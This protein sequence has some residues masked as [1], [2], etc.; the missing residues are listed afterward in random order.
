MNRLHAVLC[1][2]FALVFMFSMR[3]AWAETSTDLP[4]VQAKVETTE[5]YTMRAGVPADW[6]WN[7]FRAQGRAMHEWPAFW[8]EA[9]AASNIP[10]T[11]EAWRRIPAGTKITMP[12]DP[13]AVAADTERLRFIR[14]RDEAVSKLTEEIVALQASYR[15]AQKMLLAYGF[16]AL[17][18]GVLAVVAIAR[19]LRHRAMQARTNQE[20]H[21]DVSGTQC[22][23][24]HH[25]DETAAHAEFPGTTMPHRGEHAP[26][27]PKNASCC[28]GEGEAHGDTARPRDTGCCPEDGCTPGF[29]RDGTVT[30]ADGRERTTPIHDRGDHAG[31]RH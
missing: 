30:P 23:N 21:T 13:K 15:Q 4:G 17:V 3:L 28:D 14:E 31:H 5:T 16:A 19:L 26:S 24:T 6:L 18:F 10:C 20:L 9:C 2:M 7:R 11:E 8:Q 12:R 25:G 22:A 29:K 1:A 27:P